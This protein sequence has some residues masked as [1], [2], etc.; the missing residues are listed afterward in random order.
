MNTPIYDFV[1][2]YAESGTLRLHMPG[3]KGDG[4]LGSEKYD[5]TEIKGADSLF[6]CDGIIKES[7]RNASSVFGS[8]T[9]YSTEGSSLIIRAMIYLSLLNAKEREKECVILASRNVHK[10]F[11]SAAALLDVDVRW[12]YPKDGESYLSCKIDADELDRAIVENEPTAVYIT[13]PDYLGNIADINAISKV[14]KRRGV[15]LLVDNAHGAYLKF[16]SESQHPCDLGADICC[17]S[18]HKT[19]PALTGGAYLHIAYDAPTL[20]HEQAKDALALFASTSPSY[21]I[22][23]S[24]DLL[25][26]YLSD[27]YRDEL[28]VFCERVNRLRSDL[29]SYGYA[30]IGNEALKITIC[31][32]GFGYF[33]FE[34]AE[35]MR[36]RGIECEFCDGDNVVMM[37]TPQIGERGIKRVR[38]I[39]LS[40]ER[41]SP[42][43]DIAPHFSRPERVMSLRE[44][45]LSASEVLP[46]DECVG[47]TLALSTVACPPAVPILVCGERIDENALKCFE[48]Y[49]I[50]S[51]RVVKE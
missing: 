39:L 2:K 46:S 32:K 41:K 35:I 5:I 12:M 44:A 1:R 22:L 18:A 48:Y 13:S 20:L 49:E 23:S 26:R 28:A 40:L 36:G 38:E 6:E 3:H 17:D 24:L 47:R 30:L 16:L 11:L 7:E 10:T 34:I 51:C 45:T 50:K 19:L 8:D 31:P 9:F 4:F 21:L 15:L 25:N 27:V 43:K 33:G 42:I 29:A 14:C 37:L